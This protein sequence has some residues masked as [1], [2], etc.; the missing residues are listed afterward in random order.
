MELLL[1]YLTKNINDKTEK[2]IAEAVY[3]S[4]E[5]IIKYKGENNTVIAEINGRFL[6]SD[7]GNA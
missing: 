7:F 5:V 3:D 1:K 4:E 6:C 2:K